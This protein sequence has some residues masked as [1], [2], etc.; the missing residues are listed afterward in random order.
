MFLTEE[1][2]NFPLIIQILEIIDHELSQCN[3]HK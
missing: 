2:E 1:Q 3:F